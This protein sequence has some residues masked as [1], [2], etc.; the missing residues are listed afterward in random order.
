[1]PLHLAAIRFPFVARECLETV[2][3]SF[4]PRDWRRS[5][6]PPSG[7]TVRVP[8]VRFHPVV[9]Q[10]HHERQ[11]HIEPRRVHGPE[12]A[13]PGPDPLT[14][15]RFR[16]VRDRTRSPV[17]GPGDR[18]AEIRLRCFGGHRADHNRGVATRDGIRLHDD[19]WSRFAVVAGRGDDHRVT[20]A[21]LYRIQIPLWSRAMRRA[22]CRGS[23]LR[24]APQ[25]GC[26]RLPSA[27]PARRDATRAGPAPASRAH[28]LHS[29]GGLGNIVLQQVQP[30]TYLTRYKAE[31]N[32][33]PPARAYPGWATAAALAL[34]ST[35]FNNTLQPA[36]RSS[37]LASSISLWLMPPIQGTK[38]IAEGA[39]R[40]I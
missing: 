1:M 35:V 32:L 13:D 6:F 28:H 25:S 20:A 36:V 22:H 8:R 16:V 3:P 34:S 7:P 15:D 38:T 2:R 29:F 10:T 31:G 33:P 17:S 26:A 18:D 39:T 5:A 27:H 24:P 23:A 9:C 30:V 11:G 19:S 21:H 40:A 37:G 12:P 14:T 4:W